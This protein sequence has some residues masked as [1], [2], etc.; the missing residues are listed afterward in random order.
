MV[1][2]EAGYGTGRRIGAEL[3]EISFL[4]STIFYYNHAGMT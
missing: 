3:L 2:A 1:I 4:E